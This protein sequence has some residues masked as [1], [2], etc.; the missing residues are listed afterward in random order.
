MA[1]IEFAKSSPYTLGVELEFQVLDRS[2]LDLVPKAPEILANIPD[3]L[4]KKTAREFRKSILEIL[5]G[6]CSSVDEVAED[7]RTTVLE[8]MEIAERH[9][10]LLLASSLHPFADPAKQELSDDDRYRKIMHELQYVGRQ[11]ITQGLHIHVGVAEK[12]QA[13]RALNILQVYQPLLVALSASSPFFKGEDT[14][15]CSYRTKL[16]EALPLA[17]IAGYLD[18]WAAYEEE[19]FLL[20]KSKVIEEIRDLWWDVRPSPRFGTVEV[21]GCDLPSC[22]SH[23]LALVALTQALVA[24]SV[25]GGVQPREV[26]PQILR[27]N[28]WQAARHGLDGRFNDPLGLL[29][30]EQ[31]TIHE[32]ATQLIDVLTPRLEHFGTE[33]W[34]DVLQSILREGTS[35]AKQRYL[36]KNNRSFQEMIQVLLTDFWT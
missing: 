30:I 24:E 14:G 33:K 29:P 11:F 31:Q 32:A 36:Y 21:R 10:C 5:T 27:C 17:G 2:T 4:Q 15:L 23:I 3:Q 25:E 20:Q 28:K 26:S 35:A 13:I 12:E 18:S 7:M 19:I 9:D 34:I 16:F 6:V 8:I 22:F 1:S